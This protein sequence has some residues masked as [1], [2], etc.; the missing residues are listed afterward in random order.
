[1]EMGSERGAAS[2]HVRLSILLRRHF[3]EGFAL[4]GPS[5]S[6]EMVLE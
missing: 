3:A 6:L 5:P 1:M 2:A 4:I